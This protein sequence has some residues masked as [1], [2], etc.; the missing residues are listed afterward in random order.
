MHIRICVCNRDGHSNGGF[1]NSVLHFRR[2][3]QRLE[4]P[5]KPLTWGRD[6]GN[7]FT[8]GNAAGATL[9]NEMDLLADILSEYM[10]LAT[11]ADR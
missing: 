11:G 2:L 1:H 5:R 4:P 6:S 9:E 3:P 8:V 10:A 7:R